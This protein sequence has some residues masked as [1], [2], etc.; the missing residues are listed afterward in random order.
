MR[1]LI[2]GIVDFHER[3]LP[4]YQQR[5]EVLALMRRRMRCL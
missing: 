1:K 4:Q 2:M 5:F 3:M